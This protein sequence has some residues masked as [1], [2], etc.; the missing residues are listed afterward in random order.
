MPTVRTRSPAR[1]RHRCDFCKQTIER[2]ELH[3]RVKVKD[4]YGKYNIRYHDHCAHTAD[5]NDLVGRVG[6]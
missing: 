3:V 5:L 4:E 1:E 6:L 2:G